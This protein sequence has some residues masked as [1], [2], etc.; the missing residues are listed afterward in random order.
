MKVLKIKI[1][2]QKTI[3]INNRLTK[4]ENQSMQA[5]NLLRARNMDLNR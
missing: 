3:P 4:N 1:I 5:V 2:K